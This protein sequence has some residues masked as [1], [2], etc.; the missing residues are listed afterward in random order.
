MV[1]H[2]YMVLHCVD[3]G[4]Q[5]FTWCYTVG[6]DVTQWYGMVLH[7]VTGCYIVLQDATRCY[8]V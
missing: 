1:L 5:G 2:G 3:I 8:K 7:Y 4:I 6:H